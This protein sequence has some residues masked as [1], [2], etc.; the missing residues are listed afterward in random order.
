MNS[1]PCPPAMPQYMKRKG[2]ENFFSSADHMQVIYLRSHSQLTAR[3][4]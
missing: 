4:G 1:V 3:E 2:A